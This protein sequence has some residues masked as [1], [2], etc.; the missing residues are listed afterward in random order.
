MYTS[1]L[2]PNIKSLFSFHNAQI[3]IYISHS[4]VREGNVIL[5]KQGR[6]TN[7]ALGRISFILKTFSD[8]EIYTGTLTFTFKQE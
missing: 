3:S 5:G 6:G 2:S 1:A 4:D 8:I 7:W